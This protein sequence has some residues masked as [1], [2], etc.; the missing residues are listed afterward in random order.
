MK[1]I[2][3]NRI[4]L[5]VVAVALISALFF[6]IKLIFDASEVQKT[7]EI[8]FNET[9]ELVE[10]DSVI[11]DVTYHTAF[12]SSD[13]SFYVWYTN[14]SGEEVSLPIPAELFKVYA[15]AAY[16]PVKI[17]AQIGT[18][19]DGTIQEKNVT[20]LIPEVMEWQNSKQN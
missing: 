3:I 12:K 14:Y 16:E 1:N 20:F 6:W 2:I 8:A 15:R 19:S 13:V 7:N 18:L 4:I 10:Y 9:V 5:A 17:L 11:T